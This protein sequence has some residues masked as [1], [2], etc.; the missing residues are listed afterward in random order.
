MKSLYDPNIYQECL[1]RLA[2]ITP[3]TKPQWGQMT[4]AQMMSHCSEIQEVSNGKELKGT[5]FIVKLFSGFIKKMVFNN[6]PY[7]KNT[8][9]HPQYQMKGLSKDFDVEKKRLL[10]TLEKFHNEDPAVAAEIEHAMFGK[11]P[12]DQKGWG[13]YKH[14]DHHLT[15]FGV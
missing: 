8:K 3:E 15:Q 12:R 10:D 2:E 14:L 4:A 7:P 9:T 6:K 11:V 1:D 5:P 13:T